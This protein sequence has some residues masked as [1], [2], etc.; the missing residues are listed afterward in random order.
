M[1]RNV[2]VVGMDFSQAA[3]RAVEYAAS[4]ARATEAE[5]RIVHAWNPTGWGSGTE[6]G[7]ADLTSML[8]TQRSVAS[9]RLQGLVER[10]S[11]DGLRGV[12]ELVDGPA[13]RVLTTVAERERARLVVVGR[14]GRAGL[15]HAILGSVSE[16]VVRSAS[17]PV[18]VVPELEVDLALPDRLLVGIDFSSASRDALRAAVQFAEALECR[19]GLVLAHAFQ[20]ERE[21]WLASWSELERSHD[22]TSDERALARWARAEV[23]T[24]VP[25]EYAILPGHAETAL[26]EMAHNHDCEWIVLGVQGRTA[27]ASFLM[28][29]TT[30]RILKLTDRP[31]LAVPLQSAPESEGVD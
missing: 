22:R 8:E 18:L 15:S 7:N 5:L 21:L 12:A 29:G 17:C 11:G 26:S 16:R 31:V 27:L 1:S 30:A 24:Q 9:A 20:D 10:L 13:S 25:C 3:G 19:R 23:S 6:P 14:V 2:V 4:I 28:G